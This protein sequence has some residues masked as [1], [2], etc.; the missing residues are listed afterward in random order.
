ME[1]QT[2]QTE[3]L[4]TYLC[5]PKCKTELRQS[6]NTL[7]CQ[8]CHIDYPI[9]EGI[10]IL[11]HLDNLP[12]HL[13]NQI[14]F[15][16]SENVPE[17]KETPLD[18]WQKN[19]VNRFKRHFTD[20]N[21][22][23]VIDCGAG[24]GYMSLELAKEGAFVIACDLTLK[25]LA[26]LQN[27]ANQLGLSKNILTVCC[28]AEELPFIN[29]CANYFISNA[30]LEH[31]PREKEAVNEIKRVCQSTSGLMI[32]VPIKLKYTNPLFIPLNTIHDRKVGHLRRYDQESLSQLFTEYKNIVTYYTGHFAKVMK[33]ILN[34]AFKLFKE[35]E[36]EK[37]DQKK[38]KKRWGSNNI[39]CFFKK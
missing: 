39:I 37:Q 24:T 8:T 13:A 20:L 21:K 27:R 4:F 30:V 36:I 38:E 6:N 22:A 33:V 14:K 26:W 19:Y 5:C 17:Q 10:P 12:T 28:S 1:P 32:T 23:I 2:K 34:Y 9:Q 35:D 7:T 11:V 31:L 18:Q 16:E 15:F 29:D 25:S 3:S